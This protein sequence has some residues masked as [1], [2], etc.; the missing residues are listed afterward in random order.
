MGGAPRDVQRRRPPKA[1]RWRLDGRGAQAGACCGA[2]AP[3]C[4]APPPPG[5]GPLTSQLRS[6][7]AP[8]CID[9]CPREAKRSNESHSP[10]AASRPLHSQGQ[11]CWPLELVPSRAW[12]GGSRASSRHAGP[13]HAA[14]CGRCGPARAPWWCALLPRWSPRPATV[15]WGGLAADLR[16]GRS[17]LR[18]SPSCC[19]GWSRCPGPARLQGHQQDCPGCGIVASGPSG[20]A[21]RRD[22]AG[23]ALARAA[24]QRA[25]CSTLGHRP[26][27]P[28]IPCHSQPSVSDIGVYASIDNTPAHPRP[29]VVILGSGWAGASLFKALPESVKCVAACSRLQLQPYCSPTPCCIRC[30]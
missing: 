26:P 1:P 30:T 9:R 10:P 28:C 25:Q 15:R 27:P 7:I 21:A 24:Q 6:H 23:G 14:L 19:S 22:A 5:A 8:G 29:R 12:A 20:G 18:C 2:A 3:P 11:R 16:P 4:A 17:S 13:R